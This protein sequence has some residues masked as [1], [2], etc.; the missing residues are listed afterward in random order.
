MF[1]RHLALKDSDPWD[2]DIYVKLHYFPLS[3]FQPLSLR[4]NRPFRP[5]GL[6]KRANRFCKFARYITFQRP[7]QDTNMFMYERSWID[8]S[9]WSV[10]SSDLFDVAGM[11]WY[12]RKYYVLY[13]IRQPIIDSIS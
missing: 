3:F 1:W 4:E 7:F 2:K 5:L 9:G 8:N 12:Q 6:G 11:R 13:T 10:N